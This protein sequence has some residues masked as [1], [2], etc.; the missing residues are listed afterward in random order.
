MLG[1]LK[2]RSNIADKI[3]KTDFQNLKDEIKKES[4]EL[5]NNSLK[6][7]FEFI[8]RSKINEGFF[9]YKNFF[10]NESDIHRLKEE[11]KRDYDKDINAGRMK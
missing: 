10:R 7:N 11:L 1:Q 9:D 6:Q 5:Y 3:D 4:Y 8:I 2:F